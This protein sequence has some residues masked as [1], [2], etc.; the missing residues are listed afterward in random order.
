MHRTRLAER[1]WIFGSFL[2]LPLLG[3]SLSMPLLGMATVA[4]GI[5]FRVMAL[6][7]MTIPFHIVFGVVNDLADLE[8]DRGD[9]RK[10]GRP[11]VSGAVRPASARAL[12]LM[13]AAGAFPLDVILLGYDP[14]RSASL[15][16]ALLATAIYNLAG[17][18]TLVPPFMDLLLG[19]GSAAFVHYGALAV[20]GTPATN[21]FLVESAVI[22]YIVLNNGVHFGVRDIVR[23]YEYGA[24]TTPIIF[25]VRPQDGAPYLPRRFLVYAG[26][27]QVLLTV[28]TLG[29]VVRDA[30]AGLA[31]WSV[32][33]AA[34]VFTVGCYVF[35][36]PSID[37]A[38]SA[39]VRYIFASLQ[40]LCGFGS[41][42]T[43]ATVNHGGLV[44]LSI[45]VVLAAPLGAKRAVAAGRRLSIPSL[46]R[47]D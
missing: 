12:V 47:K 33:I 11:L 45:L 1:L 36:Y 23:D 7:C 16:S 28:A 29:P 8:L 46:R 19:V 40:S 25:G 41:V 42:A 3:W 26:C 13:A 38:R 21:T 22:I 32:V 18:R 27:L 5:P 9:P 17:K 4:D 37:G 15:A 34:L 44:A 31:S 14:A 30:S 39:S 20:T 43:L 6:V 35:I 2:R 24:R 10:A